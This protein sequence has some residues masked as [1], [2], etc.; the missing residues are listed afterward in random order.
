MPRMKRKYSTK[1]L[2]LALVLV[3]LMGVNFGMGGQRTAPSSGYRDWKVYG[4]SPDNIHYSVLRQINRDNV[5]DLKV[6]W[7]YDSRD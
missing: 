3:F 7:S 5:K 4:G 6:A 1:V 2:K